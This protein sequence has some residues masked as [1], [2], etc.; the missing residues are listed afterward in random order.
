M[1][2]RFDRLNGTAPA[3]EALLN[4]QVPVPRSAHDLTRN[5]YFS[6]LMGAIIP[7]DWI[8]TLPKSDYNYSVDLVALTHNP[9]IK[10]MFTGCRIYTHT[11]LCYDRDCWEGA[12]NRITRGRSGTI[13]KQ[14]PKIALRDIGRADGSQNYSKNVPQCDYSTV[15]SLADFLTLPITSY[16]PGD[17]DN[18]TNLNETFVRLP[19]ND[20]TDKKYKNN[21]NYMGN[22]WEANALPFVVYQKGCRKLFFNQNLIMENK[23]WFPDNEHDFILPYNIPQ[24]AD[25]S[26]RLETNNF[27]N[28]LSH[29]KPTLSA[30]EMAKLD[31]S[32]DGPVYVPVSYSDDVD[33]ETDR[34]PDET[35]VVLTALHFRQFKGDYFNTALP[36]KDL[37]RGTLPTL[38]DFGSIDWS[39]LYGKTIGTV[40]T[41]D[42]MIYPGANP[43]QQAP[44]PAHQVKAG[45][46]LVSS[47]SVNSSRQPIVNGPGLVDVSYESIL[48]ATSSQSSNYGVLSDTQFIDALQNNVKINTSINLNLLRELEAYTVFKERMA[49]ADGD[50]NSLIMAQFGSNPHADSHEPIYCGGSY[51]DVYFNDVVNQ[52]DGDNSP[53]GSK[54]SIG[55]SGAQNKT[56]RIH[57]DDFGYIMTFMEIVPDVIYSTQGID[58][59][60]SELDFEDVYFPILNNLS[61]QEIKNKELYLSENEEE[62]EEV[63]GHTER[64]HH[65]KSRQNKIGGM[66]SLPISLEEGNENSSYT[67]Y[68][69][70]RRFNSSPRLSNKFVTM[71]PGNIDMSVFSNK[72]EHPFDVAVCVHCDAVLP[73]PYTTTPSDMGLKY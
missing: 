16:N 51:Q 40:V 18:I 11:I 17:K 27:V 52:S 33:N 43:S 46:P 10:Q 67:A 6:A 62:N 20:G 23:N 68:N 25:G 22:L 36:F 39:G 70:R 24:F 72:Y 32:P 19:V 57:S 56:L 34:V 14:V 7:I 53:L 59:D 58:R 65:M 35:P 47:T 15:H 29:D 1:A 71:S 60:W 13:R 61:P 8:R 50:Y 42:D 4:K 3:L 66:M 38:E 5:K 21:V 54:A 28:V 73:L 37:I 64:F 41:K 44:I 48:G 9:L 30:D 26:D 63:F 12:Q 2:E 45:A 55:V 31:W 69:M 49:R